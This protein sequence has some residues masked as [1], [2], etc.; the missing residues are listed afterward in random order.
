MAAGQSGRRDK[1]LVREGYGPAGAVPD[2]VEGGGG[3]PA[4]GLC[5]GAAR[6]GG[7]ADHRGGHGLGRAGRCADRDQAGSGR[8]CLPDRAPH[9]D[10]ALLAAPPRQHQFQP[11][12][13]GAGVPGPDPAHQ[14]PAPGRPRG[15]TGHRALCQRA[16]GDDGGGVD[17]QLPA[18]PGGAGRGDVR[19]V[20]PADLC[21]PWPAGG[22]CA[23]GVA[24]LAAL[25]LRPVP[26]LHRGNWRAQEPLHAAIVVRCSSRRWPS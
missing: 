9:R 11:E 5:A 1:L 23:A 13:G 7:G 8:D 10:P 18:L 20:G 14:L 3:G 12:G 22:Q 15:G 26:D 24:D 16:G 21:R 6:R 17:Q 25:L 2:G 4:G 19:G